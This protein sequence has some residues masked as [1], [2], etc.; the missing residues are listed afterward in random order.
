VRHTVS[1]PSLVR[2]QKRARRHAD[3]LW[4][5]VRSRRS[6]RSCPCCGERVATFLPHG[7]PPRPDARCPF[8]GSL[9]RHRFQALVLGELLAATPV[10][11]V[12]HV[13]PEKHIRPL[14]EARPNVQW[15]GLDYARK[16]EISA[17]GDLTALGL[18]DASVDLIVCS[19]VLEHIPADRQAMAELARVLRPGGT[20][21]IDVPVLHDRPTQEDPTLG[22]ADRARLY[23]QSDHVRYYGTDTGDR[24]TAAGLEVTREIRPSDQGAAVDTHALDP[25]GRIWLC[26]R[27]G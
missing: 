25:A 13:A 4:L 15:I 12:L 19:H 10:R 24:L 18:A 14:L 21:L 1:V 9:E 20:A 2:I 11:R 27:G 16:R 22:P 3:R 7:T 26:R 8:C 5:Q 17:Q 6:A 23:G